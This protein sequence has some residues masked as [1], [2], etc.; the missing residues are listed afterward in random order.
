VHALVAGIVNRLVA[1]I[2]FSEVRSGTG[3]ITADVS[4]WVGNLHE[5]VLRVLLI[6]DAETTCAGIEVRAC[7]AFISIAE[8]PRI[9]Q[10]ACC[11]MG[12]GSYIPILLLNSMYNHSRWFVE[13]QELM[14]CV[15]LFQRANGDT[16]RAQIE[17]RAIQAFVAYAF[18]GSATHIAPNALMNNAARSR[19][20]G[21]RHNTLI[22]V[23]GMNNHARWLG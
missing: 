21:G 7:D 11:I 23:D 9:T 18:D 8:D 12:D 10:I 2:A 3:R 14:T 6:G 19:V 16:R 15:V 5:G 20:C 4:V 13:I 17:I 22:L 1:C